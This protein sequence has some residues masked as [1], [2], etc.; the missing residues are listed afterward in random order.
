MIKKLHEN[1][2]LVDPDTPNDKLIA[3]SIFD[4]D[5][6]KELKDFL[7]DLLEKLQET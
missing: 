4:L 3:P 1:N 7:K 6:I 2:Q 5:D